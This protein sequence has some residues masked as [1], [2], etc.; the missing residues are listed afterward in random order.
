M[1][2]INLDLSRHC[3]ETE[4]KRLHNRLISAYF[5]KGGAEQELEDKI[6][7]LQKALTSF[8]F[9]YLRTAYEDLSGNC[10]ASIRLESNDRS[11][12]IIFINARS[13]DGCRHLKKENG[14][15]LEEG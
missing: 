7:I 4:I 2:R 13:V 11:T 9:S 5:K 1:I 10:N 14:H 8:D 6:E 3:I 15:G 12:P